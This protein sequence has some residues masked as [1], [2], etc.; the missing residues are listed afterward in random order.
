[1]ESFLE[2]FL[3][4]VEK[5]KGRIYCS[6]NANYAG[7]VLHERFTVSSRFGFKKII[8]EK[9]GV[10][11]SVTLET[12]SR[13]CSITD[14]IGRDNAQVAFDTLKRFTDHKNSG[15]RRRLID[16]FFQ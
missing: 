7:L 1:M 8:V 4:F 5:N 15:D 14:L 2:N 6:I 11:L 10:D 3:R 12:P 13:Y 16:K 9:L